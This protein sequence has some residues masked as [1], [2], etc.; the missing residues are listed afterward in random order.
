MKSADLSTDVIG[1]NVVAGSFSSRATRPAKCTSPAKAS[2]MS[3]E[4]ATRWRCIT[5]G[6]ARSAAASAACRAGALAEQPALSTIRAL[7]VT[8]S[9]RWVTTGLSLRPPDI[10]R[11]PGRNPGA[12]ACRAQ[13]ERPRAAR[14]AP[15]VS[16][17]G[18]CRHP[19]RIRPLPSPDPRVC[20]LDSSRLL[21]VLAPARA[22]RALRR[23]GGRER[24]EPD[25]GLCSDRGA[26]CEAPGWR[27]GGTRSDFSRKL[28]V[29]WTRYSRRVSVVRIVGSRRPTSG[30]RASATPGVTGALVA[31]TLRDRA[32]VWRS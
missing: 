4:A 7:A 13:K 31:P 29:S 23:R 28:A 30:S 3:P 32:A 14:A 2:V 19:E 6:L 15:S 27:G 21:L 12:I 26:P 22:G 25:E 8:M 11:L 20:R 17:E 18:K 24:G 5:T 10:L 16:R 9:S 1:P